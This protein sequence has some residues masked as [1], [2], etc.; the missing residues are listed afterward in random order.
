MKTVSNFYEPS[1]FLLPWII[2][3]TKFWKSLTLKIKVILLAKMSLLENSS[4]GQRCN[5][6]ARGGSNKGEA[7][8]FIEK[9]VD[10]G[11]GCSGP[12]STGEKWEFRVGVVSI[13]VAGVVTACRRCW[14][15]VFLW[16]PVI[17]CSCDWFLVVLRQ[18]SPFWLPTPF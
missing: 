1:C 18:S 9:K 7:R 12:K 4:F 17:D 3:K 5:T 13:W 11:R 14:A 8:H 15:H 16:G 2:L 10:V 6:K